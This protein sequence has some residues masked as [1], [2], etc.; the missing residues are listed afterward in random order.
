[1]QVNDIIVIGAGTMGQGIAQWFV[2]KGF[3]VLLIDQDETFLN[4]TEKSI[5]EKW[6]KQ[7]KKDKI[8]F[9]VFEKFKK[10]LT[11]SPI[12]KLNK[13]NLKERKNT[14]VI[15]CIN[16][17]I[18]NKIELFKLLTEHLSAQN[19]FVSNTSGL[20]INEM[21][22]SLPINYREQF[23]GMHFFNPAPVMKLVELIPSRLTLT[24]LAPF[25]KD[26]LLSLGKVP[27]I[28]EDRPGFI[29]NRINRSFYGEPLRLL[30]NTSPEEKNK[31]FQI[32]E[33]M[34]KVGGF[35]MG[36]FELMDLIGIDINY[37]VSKQTWE[38]FHFNERFEPHWIQEQKVKCNKLGRKTGIGFYDYQTQTLT[39]NKKKEK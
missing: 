28:S 22:R 26:W 15:E 32:D 1:M 35:L 10:N 4:S 21:A 18:Q 20:S 36:P 9:D 34:R 19:Y 24:E 23:M 14:L 27:V 6:D 17:N 25:F 3:K 8:T 38:Q 5:W 16:E 13:L 37:T 33:V 2:Q 12:Q 30:K 39:Q 11:L 7:L 29:V 31:C